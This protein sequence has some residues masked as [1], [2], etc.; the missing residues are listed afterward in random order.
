MTWFRNLFPWPRRLFGVK[1]TMPNLAPRRSPG[2]YPD[3]EKARADLR[4]I[5]ARRHDVDNL[6]AALVIERHLNNFS[7]NLTATFRGGSQ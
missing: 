6:V 1:R 3:V 4:R 7:A 2:D 5:Q